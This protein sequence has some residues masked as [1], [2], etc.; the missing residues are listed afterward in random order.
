M[1]RILISSNLARVRLSLLNVDR[2]RAHPPPAGEN[3]SALS[4]LLPPPRL[5]LC[6]RLLLPYHKKL[7]DAF[8]PGS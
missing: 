4:K 3:N 1:V 7:G 5:Q 8:P 2:H 6:L